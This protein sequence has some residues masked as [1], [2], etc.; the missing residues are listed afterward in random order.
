MSPAVQRRL[1]V[2][3][4]SSGVAVPNGP[5][6]AS[7]RGS[8]SARCPS[9][10][11]VTC[12]VPPSVTVTSSMAPSAGTSVIAARRCPE[13][14]SRQRG[15]GQLTRSQTAGR[16]RS[17]G[18]SL[19]VFMVVSASTPPGC[20]AMPA[21]RCFASGHDLDISRT[22]NWA[23]PPVEGVAAQFA[24]AASA[25]RYLWRLAALRP[26]GR[27]DQRDERRDRADQ[28]DERAEAPADRHAQP[29]RVHAAGARLDQEGDQ[30]EQEVDA[31]EPDQERG[32]AE[33]EVDREVREPGL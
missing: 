33:R 23:A 28:A 10:P 15:H 11:K 9:G 21:G 8:K 25:A 19:I 32:N 30:D 17:A 20:G 16:P 14:G 27:Q 22:R 29:G 18:W 26:G 12:T 7:Q 5:Y 6:W 24:V 3:V 2:S 1:A 31:G 13:R 4:R